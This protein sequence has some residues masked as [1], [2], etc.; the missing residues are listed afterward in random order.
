MAKHITNPADTFSI[1]LINP[2]FCINL[3]HIS[4]RKIGK[5]KLNLLFTILFI[6][7]ISKCKLI[8]LTTSKKY[9][10]S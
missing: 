1:M 7:I 8:Y 6:L 9:A 2:N 4:N 5:L 10:Q 3:E